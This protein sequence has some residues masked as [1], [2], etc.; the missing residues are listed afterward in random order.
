MNPT[1]IALTTM[2][3]HHYLSAWATGKFRVLP[4]CGTGGGAQC[5]CNT[6]NINQVVSHAC[7]EGCCHLNA[8]FRLSSQEVPNNK[9]DNICSKIHQRIHTTGMDPAMAQPHKD[10]GSCDEDFLDSIPEE[11]VQQPDNSFNYLSSF[12]AATEQCMQFSAVVPMSWPAITSSSQPVSCSTSNSNIITN[13]TSVEN[14]GF[15][16]WSANV[17]CAML[18]WGQQ[19]CHCCHGA[20]RYEGTWEI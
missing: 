8:D 1:F 13:I 7:T 17:E 20:R 18:L 2:G 19:W 9:I 5:K 14:T 16:D 12:V 3:I 4:E 15:V 6:R 11:L 10:Q